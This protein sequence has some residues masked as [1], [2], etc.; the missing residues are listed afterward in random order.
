MGLDDT[1]SVDSEPAG[2][3]YATKDDIVTPSLAVSFS[4]P[5][6][7]PADPGFGSQWHLRNNYYPDVDLNITAVWDD[8]TGDGVV[9]GVMDTGIDY[10]HADLS[11][12]YR[13]DLDYDALTGD[14]DAYASN[15]YDNH[16]TAVAGVIG[17]TLGG[18]R[19]V[20]V[21]P[22][23]DIAGF[24]VGF[25]V[26]SFM[27]EL[28]ALR[29]ATNVDVLN[30][31]WGY[32]G[33]FYDNFASYTFAPI[34]R[35]FENLVT[36]GRDGLG[37]IITFSSGNRRGQGD[38]VNYHSYLSARETIA[39]GAVEL[40]GDYSSFSTPGAAMLVSAPGT[41]IYTTDARGSAGYNWS[42]YT[43][44][45]GTSFSAPAVA[46]VAALML[47]ANSE[48][49]HRD[50]QEILAYSAINPRASTSGWQDNGALEWNGGGL[51][52]SHDYGFGLVDAHAA[53]R[54][55]E[56]W[57]KQSTE[58]NVVKH[59]YNNL[60]STTYIADQGS[61]TKYFH[62]DSEIDV[63]HVEAYLNIGHAWIGDLTVE[64]T[65]PDGTTSTLVD[66]PGV[67]NGYSTYGVSQDNINFT[68][69]SVA[70]WGETAAGQWSLRV[71]DAGTSTAGY[72]Y[73]WD[74]AF[75]GDAPGDDDT[76][77]Y[78]S[79]W[80]R[81]G[82][83]QGRAVIT[84]DA[85]TDTLNLAAIDT[86]FS[87]DL[88][89]GSVTTLLGHAFTIDTS[90]VIENAYGGDG[91]DLITGNAAGNR[92]DGMRG[93]DTLRGEDG[94]DTLIG[95]RGNDTLFGGGGYDVAEFSGNFANY[96]LTY[97][98]GSVTVAG[99][100]GVDQLF[101]IELLQFAD[102]ALAAVTLKAYD[103]V[104]GT[105]EDQAIVLSPGSLLGNDIHSVQE[106]LQI[107]SVGSAAHG[108]V[109]INVDGFVVYTPDANFSGVDSFTYTASNDAGMTD[110]ATVSVTVSAVADV[111]TVAV[112]LAEPVTV[113]A[114]DDSV[115]ARIELQVSA[116]TTDTDG[117]ETLSVVIDDLPAG[118]TL[119]AG[120][121][122]P[123]GA[124][125]VA[126]EDLE[127]LALLVPEGS[128]SGTPITIRA[129]TTE[130]P[131]GDTASATTT[132]TLDLSAV[133]PEA[134]TTRLSLAEDQSLSGALDAADF[135]GESL[136]FAL[137]NAPANGTLTLAADGTY[138]YSP[139]ADFFGEDHFDVRITDASGLSADG[140]ITLAVAGVNDAPDARDDVGIVA[141]GDSYVVV[142]ARLL[143]NDDDVDGDDLSITS[144]NGEGVLL[145]ADGDVVITTP[146]GFEGSRS[147]GYTVADGQG[148]SANATA[149]IDAFNPDGLV[150]GSADAERVD[151]DAQGN[152]LFG[153]EGSDTLYGGAGDDRYVFRRGDGADVVLDESVTTSQ[154]YISSNYWVSTGEGDG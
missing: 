129:I 106:V 53:V 119:T 1:L 80:G 69:T 73:D 67:Y 18:G 136:S 26:G 79:E 153:L 134:I 147:F 23:A 130:S 78:T 71:S 17:A 22:D 8:Y 24:R 64:L 62:V 126:A 124:W 45:S 65:S 102:Q 48:L 63:Q 149:K 10:Y 128:V 84:D 154:R 58:A 152:V 122:A 137:I 127:G 112:T 116:S 90:T 135:G 37:T 114:A 25:G 51:T 75:Y 3:H 141:F 100:D 97:E 16:G 47:E 104:V 86:A 57:D 123:G 148:G 89:P 4:E 105:A 76:Y 42:D 145:N 74:L 52:F 39:V 131:N 118:A 138:A 91:G 98:V 140:R 77:V 88:T 2:S 15:S 55:A 109:S 56:T 125:Q 110:S 83:D 82:S 117:S 120:T 96:E 46:G 13:H 151:G 60:A 29:N 11:A 38:D 33:Y 142:A 20:G 111:P 14:S 54:L 144:I 12:N 70:H 49:G 113:R 139:D 133:A 32:K 132:A 68:F 95:G 9:V 28:S 31:S 19:A 150:F 115:L 61:V 94:D 92:L 85:G 34:E 72:L 30:N 21:A 81:L 121:G 87:L 41:G 35:E 5:S 107:T 44:I 101:D 27:Q 59:Q 103:D 50:V 43:Y 36:D 99:A 40:D 146:A 66:R 7:V 108:T 143:G 93:D 6:L